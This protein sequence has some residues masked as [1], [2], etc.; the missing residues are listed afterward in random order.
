MKKAS[1]VGL[2]LFSA[3]LIMSFGAA[4]A[5]PQNVQ[6][7]DEEVQDMARGMG[8][9][10]RLCGDLQNRINE[11]IAISQ[12]ALSDDEKVKKLSEALAQSLAGM[13]KSGSKDPEIGNTMN[14]YL[15]LI[16]DLVATAQVSDV[17]SDKNISAAAKNELQKLL[18]LT[19]NYV[20]M[21]KLMCPK[22]VLPEA[23]NK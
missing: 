10:P 5:E 7:S 17:G 20:Q 9:D 2:I 22:L 14:Q 11:I 12:S 1:Q 16:K 8:L 13:Q 4:A 3:F 21:M 6:P 18:I 23:M 19:K 15:A